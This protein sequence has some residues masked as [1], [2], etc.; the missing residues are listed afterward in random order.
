MASPKNVLV[1]GGRGFIGTN[2][3]ESLKSDYHVI[4]PSHKELDLLSQED[5]DRFFKDNAVDYVIHCAN[6]GGNRKAGYIPDTVG[7][8]IR[9]F[10]NLYRNEGRFEKMIHFGSGAEYS[11]DRMPPRVREEFFGTCIPGDDYGFSKYAVSRYIEQARNIYCLRLF[12]VYGPHEDYEY[13]FISNAIVKNLLHL[14]IRIV[15]DVYFDWLYVDDLVSIVR[16]FLANDPVERAYN[17]TTGKT[18]SLLQ[19]VRAIND[20]SDYRSTVIVQNNGLNKEYSG[21]NSRLAGVLGDFK[22]AEVED[23]IPKLIAYYRDHLS[24]VDR[25]TIEKDPYASKCKIS[26]TPIKA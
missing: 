21:D 10:L 5:T 8:N 13:K 2:L 6:V 7:K 15:Q 24:E 16:Y 17:A 1:T 19:I 9:M 3:F 22:F 25:E 11:K 23:A 20:H 18:A 14:P 12:G 4:A 26:S